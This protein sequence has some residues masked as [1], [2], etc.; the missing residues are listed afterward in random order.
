MTNRSNKLPMWLLLLV[1]LLLQSWSVAF[2][3]RQPAAAES[4]FTSWENSAVGGTGGYVGSEACLHCHRTVSNQ[5]MKTVHKGT[6]VA[7]TSMATSCETCHGPGKAHADAENEA[8]RTDTKNPEAK[9][10][11][12]RFDGTPQ[13]N[14]ARCLTC[15]GTSK[16]HDLFKRS[17]HNLQAVSCNECHAV[18]LVNE[19]PGEVVPS[20]LPQAR[21]VSAPKLVEETRWLNESLLKK[22]QPELCFECHR[23]IEAQF[24]LPNHHRVPEGLM[25]CS[26]CHSPHGSLTK[27]LLKKTSTYETCVSCH[28]EKRGPFVYEH[29]SVKVEGCTMCHTPHGSTNQHLLV[30]AEV[31]FV[32]MSCHNGHGSLSYQDSGACTRCHVTIHGSNASEVFVK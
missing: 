25:K 11:I 18:H 20:S 30:R 13:A 22:T 26:D 15:H 28:V 5:L 31:R 27:S 10:L 1:F 3:Q 19:A 8:D 21:F 24:A 7:G 12:Y 2:A 17:E 6:N 4:S 23:S 32:C 16:E 29:A 9:K 14:A